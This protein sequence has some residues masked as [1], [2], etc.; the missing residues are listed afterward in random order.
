MYSQRQAKRSGDVHDRVRQLLSEF[1]S[2]SGNVVRVYKDQTQIA[3]CITFATRHMRQYFACFPEILLVD[4]THGTNASQYKLFSFMVTDGF[5]HG[6]FVQHALIDAENLLN[7][8]S[9]VESFKEVHPLWSER[10]KV[11]VV[12]AA[13][14]HVYINNLNCN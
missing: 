5:G 13:F 1:S 14:V 2:E 7:M 11:I 3:H 4:A 8:T 9:A 12:S 10:L 6:Q